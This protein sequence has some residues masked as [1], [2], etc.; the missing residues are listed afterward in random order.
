MYFAQKWTP[1]S[2]AS[3]MAVD[4]WC[5]RRRLF[6]NVTQNFRDCKMATTGPYIIYKSSQLCTAVRSNVN[7]EKPLRIPIRGVVFQFPN[8]SNTLPPRL[9]LKSFS[10]AVNT[11]CQKVRQKR[12]KIFMSRQNLKQTRRKPRGKLRSQSQDFNKIDFENSIAGTS[13]SNVY[14]SRTAGFLW[15]KESI[16]DQELNRSEHFSIS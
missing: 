3:V 14:L 12:E 10:I 13:A 11:F 7:I 9:N 6:W 5:L 15:Q 8:G 4:W 16:T 2:Q 1:S